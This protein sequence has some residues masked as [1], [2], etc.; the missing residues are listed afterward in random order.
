[1]ANDVYAEHNKR[2]KKIM[3][4]QM[5]RFKREGRPDVKIKIGKRVPGT[6]VKKGSKK[7]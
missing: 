3:E 6:P 2:E 4:E 5:A 7:K 1:M